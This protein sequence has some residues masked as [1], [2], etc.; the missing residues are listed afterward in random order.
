MSDNTPNE[1]VLDLNN[2]EVKAAVQSLIDA[3]VQGLKTKNNELIQT[4]KTLK[5][6][7][8]GF[9]GQ[10]DGLDINVVKALVQKAGQDEETRLLAEGKIDE[11]MNRRTE[12]M[13]GDF[14]KQLE[15][16]KLRADKSEAFANRFRDRVLSDSIREAAVKTGAIPD[17]MDDIV[18]RA[19]GVFTLNEE[20]NPVAVDRDG[21]AIMGKDGKT[22]LTPIEWAEGLKET[23]RHLWP[24]PSGGGAQG[25]GTPNRGAGNMG[26]SR[27][28][29]QAA[30]ASKYNL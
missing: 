11:V 27:E 22:P 29:R 3:E 13:R 21:N 10:F 5:D 17:A 28:E 4:N 26:G 24:T 8:N 20:G 18:L 30:I 9:K 16:E 7:F 23:A 1:Q 15:A 6:E 25:G 19:R 14:A 2:P 12:L